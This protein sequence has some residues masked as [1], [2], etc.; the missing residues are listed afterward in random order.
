MRYDDRRIIFNRRAIY[1]NY[2]KKRNLNHIRGYATPFFVHPTEEE[3]SQLNIINH[4]W[5]IGDRY[6]K[7]AHD[8]YG[9]VG[10]WWVIAGFNQKPTEAH[11]NLGD[12]VYIP[13]PLDQVLFFLG[14]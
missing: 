11:L 1:Q 4:V 13:H 14:M 5:T 2:L 12:I 6:Y 9:D 7:L 10:Y 3:I 8:H